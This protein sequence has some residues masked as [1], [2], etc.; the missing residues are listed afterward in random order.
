MV[1]Q[2]ITMYAVQCFILLEHSVEIFKP[3]ERAI[4]FCNLGPSKAGKKQDIKFSRN[5]NSYVLHNRS[6]M[7]KNNSE[8]Q[9]KKKWL[10]CK[11]SAIIKLQSISR[12]YL[13]WAQH[14]GELYLR[15]W[16]HEEGYI[17]L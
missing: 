17:F 11:A 5:E 16:G 1:F 7:F 4:T 3:C 2:F 6:S 12:G 8:R 9:I 15:S 14:N 13:Y 10:Q